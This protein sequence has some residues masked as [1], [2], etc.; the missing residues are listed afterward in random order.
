MNRSIGIIFPPKPFVDKELE[1]KF[2]S[3]FSARYLLNRQAALSVGLFTWTFFATWDYYHIKMLSPA[4]DHISTNM[5][6]ARA[7]GSITVFMTLGLMFTSLGRN[8]RIVTLAISFCLFVCYALLLYMILIMPFPYDYLYYY[9]GLF[10]VL[11]FMFSFMRLR[12][13]AICFLLLLFVPLSVLCFYQNNIDGVILINGVPIKNYSY[14]WLAA[15]TFLIAFVSVGYT[16]S[17]DFEKSARI[18]FIRENELKETKKSLEKKNDDTFRFLR[19]ASHDL[20]NPMHALGMHLHLALEVLDDKASLPAKKY[21][22]T[23]HLACRT[24]SRSFHSLLDLTALE[25]GVHPI[26]YTVF[27]INAL[28]E[29]VILTFQPDAEQHNIILGQTRRSKRIAYA[30]SDLTLLRRVLDN[31]V[32]NGIKYSVQEEH[33]RSFVLIDIM[34][35][36]EHNSLIIKVIDNGRG[37]PESEQENVFKPYCQLHN[38]HGDRTKGLGLGL[39]IVKASVE[40]LYNHKFSMTSSEGKGTTFSVQIP[41][42]RGGHTNNFQGNKIDKKN[43]KVLDGVFILLIQTENLLLESIPDLLK[44][45]GALC[46]V[47]CS[48]EELNQMLPNM[49]RPPDLVLTDYR[50]PDNCT[51]E[52][53]IKSIEIEFGLDI[54]VI[55][56]TGDALDQDQY[57]MLERATILRKPILPTELVNSIRS[58]TRFYLNSAV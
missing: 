26:D 21:I 1:K 6:A 47:V 58:A 24:L 44:I 23:A 5:Y 32:S 17:V 34:R 33:H 29:D 35:S 22:Q 46:E 53:V 39:S 57:A 45:N 8:E 30:K 51:A 16:I 41:L 50:L 3:D 31:L 7:I 20:K 54:P 19:D 42:D 38:P 49:E 15:T 11:L 14:F 27:S 9:I 43:I 48:V 52:D 10:L 56:T 37:I 40:R 55:V 4:L 2:L 12:I 25:S 28:V 18:T 13:R 36:A